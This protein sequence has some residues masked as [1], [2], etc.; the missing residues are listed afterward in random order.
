VQEENVVAEIKDTDLQIVEPC[1]PKV[2]EQYRDPIAKVCRDNGWPPGQ[3]VLIAL[4]DGKICTCPC[5]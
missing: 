2:C 3:P 1:P 5:P 4:P